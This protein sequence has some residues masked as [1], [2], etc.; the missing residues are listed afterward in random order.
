[1]DFKELLVSKKTQ[2]KLIKESYSFTAKN[3]PLWI[4]SVT[5]DI[6]LRQLSEWLSFLPWDF[7][8]EGENPGV[9]FKN[10]EFS[11]N[12]IKNKIGFDF[13][14]SDD[15]TENILED[16]SFWLVPIVFVENENSHELEEF[17]PV[18][19]S[20]N[21]FIFQNKNIWDIYYSIVKYVENYKFPYDNKALVKNVLNTAD[22]LITI[23]E[24]EE[25]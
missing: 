16:F 20:W 19:T 14:V 12:K 22:S 10:V 8:I 15:R 4:I 11:P 2:K 24:L 13:I 18:A 6:D 21:S 25:V 1:M 3:K 5:E 23:E 17:N 7:L 9:D